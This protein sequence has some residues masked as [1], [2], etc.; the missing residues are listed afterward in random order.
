[1]RY[2]IVKRGLKNLRVCGA[3]THP[4]LSEQAD[5]AVQT[6]RKMIIKSAIYKLGCSLL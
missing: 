3:K 1:M 2:T 6:S 5:W 4:L